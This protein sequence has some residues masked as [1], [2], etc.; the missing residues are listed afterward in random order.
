MEKKWLNAAALLLCGA[1]TAAGLHGAAG[2]LATGAAGGADTDAQAEG[3]ALSAPAAEKSE[4]VYVLAGPDG[5]VQRI[6]VSAHLKNAGTGGI[7]DRSDLDNVENVKGD[8]SCTEENGSLVWDAD[9]KDIYYRGD[10]DLSLPVTVTVT[11][12]LDG[13]EVPLAEMAGRSGRVTLRFTYENHLKQTVEIDGVQQEM[14]VPFAVM[15]GVLLDNDVFSDITVTNGKAVDDGARTAV[16]GVAFPGLAE[17]LNLGDSVPGLPAFV[18]VTATVKDFRLGNTVTVAGCNLFG[19]VPDG[20]FDRADTAEEQ[21]TALAEGMQALREGSAALYDGVR[22][23]LER[24]GELADGMRAL[25]D[26]ATGLKAGTGSLRQGTADLATGAGTLADGLKQLTDSNDE[27]RNGATAVFDALLQTAWSQLT[28]AGL[29]LPVMTRDNYQEVLAQVLTGLSEEAIRTQVEQAVLRQAETHRP[30]VASAVTAAVQAQVLDGIT[31]AALGMGG[32]DYTAAVESGSIPAAV[33]AQVQAAVDAQMQ[34][35]EVQARMAVLTEQK[36]EEIKARALA[37]EEAQ[38]A[39]AA[40]L[41]QGQAGREKVQAL[42]EQ[43]TDYARFYDGLLTY[44]EGVQQAG[45]GAADVRDGANAVR[46]GAAAVDEGMAELLSGI[47]QLRDGI[48]TLLAGVEQLR[49]GASALDQGLAQFDAE[50]IARLAE[51]G[52]GLSDL[53]VRLRACADL[54][55]AYRNFSGATDGTEGSVRFVYRT[56]EV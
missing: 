9:G 17:N 52:N 16:L 22:T 39:L 23:L 56:P 36:M 4:T 43:L 29:T 13:Q 47:L 10:S 32:A 14:F 30:E 35:P 8:A 44:T 20:L 37:G 26:G 27:L 15:T 3:P 24:S 38:Q 2:V 34:S 53:T 50:G 55:G 12:L 45:D 6:I 49:D 40:A 11:C 19:K 42:S 25:A 1:V 48:P 33:Q 21:L 7:L 31:Q 28:A 54:A 51:L 18:E 41:A 5:Q 46:D